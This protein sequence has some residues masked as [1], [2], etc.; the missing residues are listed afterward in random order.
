MQPLDP[1]TLFSIFE[2]GDEE[3]YQEH[4]IE[5][6]LKNPY[7]LM[8]MVLEGI[9][10]YHIM[11]MMYMNRYPDKY[12]NVRSITKAKFYAKLYGY[13]T[14]IDSTNFDQAY[15]IGESFEYT[16]VYKGLDELR[17]F[18][19]TVEQ[20]EKCAIVKNY[21]DLLIDATISTIKLS[22]LV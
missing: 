14:R 20:Y 13:L 11:D 18:F 2:K 9:Q 16:N 21:Q 19:Q 7:V 22:N 15:T 6:T 12:T 4:G 3:V 10:N 5:D 17:V 1:H 8:G